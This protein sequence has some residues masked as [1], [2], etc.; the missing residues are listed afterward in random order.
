YV[1]KGSDL[2][3]NL[4]NDAWFGRSSAPRQLLDMTRMRAIE[5][6]IWI[7]R[8]ANTGISALIDPAGQTHGETPIFETVSMTGQVELG[9]RPSLYRR[10]G[11]LLPLISLFLLGAGLVWIVF[12]R[13]QP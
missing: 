10:I 12:H 7:A 2:L 4:T 9:A 3:V 6:R 13:R 1:R 8:A 5:N 11:D